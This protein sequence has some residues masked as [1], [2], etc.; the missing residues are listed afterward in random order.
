V[1]IQQQSDM[2]LA[3]TPSHQPEGI[4]FWLGVTVVLGAVFLG[5][6]AVEWT[7]DYHEA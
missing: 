7:H 1:L 6:K 4:A 3:V 2:V 5:I